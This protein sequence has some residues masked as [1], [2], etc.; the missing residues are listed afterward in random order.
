VV[1]KARWLPLFITSTTLMYKGEYEIGS[2]E[3]EGA[4]SDQR[5]VSVSSGRVCAEPI[6]ILRLPQPVVR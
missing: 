6:L 2:W 4:G 3:I 5:P 1:A